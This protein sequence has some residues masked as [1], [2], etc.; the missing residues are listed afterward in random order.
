MNILKST[1]QCDNLIYIQRKCIGDS[2]EGLSIFSMGKLDGTMGV[3]SSVNGKFI[4]RAVSKAFFTRS[5]IW[6]QI[7]SNIIITI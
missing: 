7:K 3:V 2:I 4:P 5:F 1:I 6:Y